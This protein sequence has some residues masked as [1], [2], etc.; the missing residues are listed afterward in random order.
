MDSQADKY[1]I[2]RHIRTSGRRCQSPAVTGSDFCFYPGS[3]AAATRPP[4]LPKSVPCA[5]KRFNICWRTARIRPS[6]HPSRPQL[7]AARRRRVHPLHLPALRSHRRRPD[8]SRPGPAAL[9]YALQVASFNVRALILPPRSATTSPHS[10]AASSHPQRPGPRRAWR[11]KRR[12]LPT[13]PP[14]IPPGK[15]DRGVRPSH[16]PPTG[17]N[18]QHRMNTLVVAHCYDDFG[19]I[20][21]PVLDFHLK[22]E[23]LTTLAVSSSL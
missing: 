8:R 12:P 17:P 9:L 21:P 7:P 3:S 23:C 16:A 19:P 10:L 15:N 1:A 11:R 20:I 5:P 18:N 22:L 6:S 13:Q 14:Q 4:A 2:C